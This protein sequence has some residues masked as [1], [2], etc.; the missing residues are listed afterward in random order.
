MTPEA[1]AA[2]EAA[3]AAECRKVMLLASGSRREETLR[4][5]ENAGF[6]RDDKTLLPGPARNHRDRAA[7][8]AEAG[9]ATTALAAPAPLRA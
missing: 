5:Y 9:P 1:C 8:G 7:G 4:F 3:W 2:L 6:E